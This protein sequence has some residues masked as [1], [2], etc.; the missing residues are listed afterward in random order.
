MIQ[1]S[2]ADVAWL[3]DI[4]VLGQARSLTF[5]RGIDEV[6]AL[7]RADADESDIDLFT[8]SECPLPEAVRAWRSGE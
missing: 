8:S 2:Q 7:R 3:Y 1:V 5:I 4:E 6:E